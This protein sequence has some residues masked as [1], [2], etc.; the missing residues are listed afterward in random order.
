MATWQVPLELALVVWVA[1]VAGC[2]FDC[3]VRAI[4]SDESI[5]LACDG[6]HLGPGH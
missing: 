5:E 3:A 1:A 6:L 4:N 2:I